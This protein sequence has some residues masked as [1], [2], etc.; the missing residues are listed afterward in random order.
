M[1]KQETI[2][3]SL[4]NR[5]LNSVRFPE[6]PDVFPV[7]VVMLK[8][9]HVSEKSPS[10]NYTSFRHRHTFFEVHVY[11]QGEQTYQIKDR[12]VRVQAG[13]VLCVAP[14]VYHAIPSCSEDLEKY[15]IC[16]T[17]GSRNEPERHHPEC[18][19]ILHNT[20]FFSGRDDQHIADIFE[21]IL[22]EA[23]AGQG[24][25]CNVVRSLIDA[26]LYKLVRIARPEM[27]NSDHLELMR[28]SERRV[29]TI[30][31]FIRDNIA[32][33]LNSG[34]IA[35]Y[36][37]LSS[38][39]LNRNVI[40]ERDTTLKTLINLMRWERACLLLKETNDTIA[41]IGCSIGFENDSSFTRFFWK[42][43]GCS[44]SAFRKTTENC[45]PSATNEIRTG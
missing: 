34:I 6:M 28:D 39:Q 9:I 21:L 41:Q 44:P 36:M 19:E 35:K 32:C 23:Y 26:L 29:L 4:A 27:G 7:E 14:Y 8:R 25:W 13:D 11:I 42:M 40:R 3:Y 18:V 37:H 30:E 33:P 22:H 24:D 12:L 10:P 20:P 43:Q 45:S 16:F 2:R 17:L 1:K 38:K 31:R 5:R 15:A